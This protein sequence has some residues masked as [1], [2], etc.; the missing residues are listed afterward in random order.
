MLAGDCVLFAEPT[1]CAYDGVFDCDWSGEVVLVA[2]PVWSGVVVELVLVAGVWLVTGGVACWFALP[3]E[4]ASPAVLVDEAIPGFSLEEPLLAWQVSATLVTLVAAI[5]WFA[6]AAEFPVLAAE[7][8]GCVE[9]FA[10]SDPERLPE[11]ET[12]FP[13]FCESCDWSPVTV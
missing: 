9:E 6:P 2:A 3:I 13:T 8:S 4:L 11:T 10:D 12:S 1:G 5:V 7:V